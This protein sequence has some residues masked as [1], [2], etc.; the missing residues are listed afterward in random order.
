M[1]E[2]DNLLCKTDKIMDCELNEIRRYL[3]FPLKISHV[4]LR[5]HNTWVHRNNR[6]VNIFLCFVFAQE[7]K[8]YITGVDGKVIRA[9]HVPRM[10]II[11]PGTVCNS[12][13][14]SSRHE[15]FFTYSPALRQIFDSFGFTSCNFTFTR[16]FNDVFER[17]KKSLE[18]VR[19]PGM[20]D[21][22][23]RLAVELANEAMLA[24]LKGEKGEENIVPDERI[25][26]ISHF[27]DF[28]FTQSINIE[29]L[30]LRQNMTP[31]TFYREWHKYYNVT[32]AQYLMNLRMKHAKEHL[33]TS[34][35][36]IFELAEKCGF[37]DAMYFSRC[38]KKH[39]GMTPKQFRFFG[40]GNSDIEVDAF[41]KPAE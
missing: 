24:A 37:C 19:E 8:E 40:D 25:F 11:Y 5:K 7:K 1:D 31:R 23:D 16:E 12:I 15:L 26:N 21:R 29:K 3:N 30:I 6:T 32:P 36:K 18:N 27:L 20:A 34:N 33:R 22:I 13:I 2:A 14:S 9:S 35:C 10:G 4:A 38:F 17:L 39:V 28:H 41:L